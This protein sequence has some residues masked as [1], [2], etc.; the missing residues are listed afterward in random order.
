V[1]EQWRR[2]SNAPPP[3]AARDRKNWK[4]QD[5][6]HPFLPFHSSPALIAT[7]TCKTKQNATT[8]QMAVN[9]F[10][11]LGPFF[12]STDLLSFGFFLL[13]LGRL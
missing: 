4:Q 3:L 10:S 13:C 9:F 6:A 2:L 1:Q 7:V 5:L 11:V 8:Q 12:V